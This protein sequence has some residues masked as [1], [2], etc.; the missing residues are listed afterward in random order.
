MARHRFDWEPVAAFAVRGTPKGQ[1][2][3]RAALR[4]SRAGVY[5]PGTADGWKA[6]VVAA[7]ES[8][9]PPDPIEGPVRVD[10]CLYLKRPKAKCRKADPEEPILAT[11]KPDRDNAEKAILDALTQA[12]WWR[13][14]A[15]VVDGR[16][17]KMYHSKSGIPGALIAI[18]RARNP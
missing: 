18:S 15:Q 7:G 13:D 12:G 9:R 6:L 14:D 8:Q 10:V 16:V 5:D 4:G 17:V 3:A 1:P 2:R 11:C